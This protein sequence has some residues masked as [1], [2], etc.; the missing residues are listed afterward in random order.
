MSVGE[1]ADRLSQLGPLY[2]LM[3]VACIAVSPLSGIPLVTTACGLSIAALSIQ[4]LLGRRATWLP[5][6]L[7][8]RTVHI[9]RLQSG[10]RRADSVA[11]LIEAVFDR[12]WVWL[13]RGPARVLLL[14]IC[15]LLGLTMPFLEVIPF[16]G[17]AFASVVLVIA[18]AFLMRDGLAALVAGVF[19]CAVLGTT[20]MLI[21]S[22]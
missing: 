11:G 21:V 9:H 18:T 19:V 7:R 13:T 22:T 12:R 14:C 8:R 4:L 5:G 6:Q 10:L 20:S 2:L 15:I 1:I 3:A 17:T 16:A